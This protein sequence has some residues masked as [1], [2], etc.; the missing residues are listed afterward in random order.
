MCVN[1]VTCIARELEHDLVN[2]S[3]Q[4]AK[5]DWQAKVKP[6]RR[7]GLPWR[8]ADVTITLRIRW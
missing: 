2:N 5:T 7:G 1:M 3:I 6:T 8:A 4:G